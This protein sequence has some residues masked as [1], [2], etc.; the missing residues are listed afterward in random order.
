M[1]P[2]PL[3]QFFD[4]PPPPVVPYKTPALRTKPVRTSPKPMQDRLLTRC[5]P[6]HHTAIHAGN[7]TLRSQPED[8][9]VGAQHN[10]SQWIG[11]VHAPSEIVEYG[12]ISPWRNLEH[13]AVPKSASIRS[14]PIK[15]ASR[16]EYERLGRILPVRVSGKTVEHRQDALG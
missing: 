6:K 8:V 14:R 7:T 13:R 10:R 12:F 16:I 2:Q 4:V 3:T 15:I 11:S 5:Q 9:A 1:L